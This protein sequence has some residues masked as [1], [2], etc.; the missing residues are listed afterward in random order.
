VLDTSAVVRII[1]G[2]SQA[3]AF[4]DAVES[5]QLVL[6]PALML[7]EVA[8]TLWRLQRAGQLQAAT[9]QARLRRAADLIDHIEPDRTLQ[10]EALALATHLDHPVYDCLY[11][12]LARREVASL[13]SADQRLLDLALK[14][15]P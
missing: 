10:A 15:L 14:V 7:T 13:L 2:S 4:T 9:L 1:E 12:V 6:A 3:V 5:A 11:L 8:N